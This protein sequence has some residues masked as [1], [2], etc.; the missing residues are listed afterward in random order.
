M[1]LVL[2]EFIG[3]FCIVYLDD[4]IIYSDSNNNHYGHIEQVLKKL[5]NFNLKINYERCRFMTSQI[6]F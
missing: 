5:G 3:R 2:S 6:N 4:I 1:F